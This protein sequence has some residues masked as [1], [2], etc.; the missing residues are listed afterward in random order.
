MTITAP[1]I[2]ATPGS[3]SVPDAGQVMG[4]IQIG[5]AVTLGSVSAA[6]ILALAAVA[7]PQGSQD[8]VDVALLAR[9]H[10]LHEEQ[11]RLDGFDVEEFDPAVPSRKFSV[12]RVRGLAFSGVEPAADMTIIRGD[13]SSVMSAAHLGRDRRLLLKKNARFVE[14]RGYRPLAVASAAMR[15]DGSLEPMVVH[16]FVPLRTARV[17]GFRADVTSRPDAW[18][19][20]PVWPV[21]LRWLHWLNLV[22]L[23]ALGMTGYYIADPFFR[24][25]PGTLGAESFMGYVRLVHYT[26][27]WGWVTLGAI[28]LYLLFFSRDRFIRWPTLW[29][30]K[31]GQDVRNLRGI[32]ASYLL[33]RHEAPTYLTHN[34]LQQFAYTGVYLMAVL[35]ALT[36]FALYGLYN[37]H[38]GFWAL[39]QW[40]VD[41]LGAPTVRLVHYLIMLA[42]CTFLLLH[43]YL[44]ARS[45]TIERHG[46]LSSMLSGGVWLR[47]GSHPVDDPTL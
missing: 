30:L 17:N 21:T 3:A 4:Q 6:R 7:A 25:A 40:P 44:V 14:R 1:V 11:G 37:A 18:V 28:R 29:P 45:D 23:V 34:P 41:W 8:P 43:L 16:G 36:G 26:V 33:I 27:A 47:R 20:V 2:D 12:T 32:L 13:L 35:Q 24:P 19:R 46:G 31:S 42:F 5:P 9:A 22:A 15:A 39:F 38:G 10:A